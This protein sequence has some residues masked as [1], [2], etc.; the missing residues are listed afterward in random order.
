MQET[1]TISKDEKDTSNRMIRLICS[2][3]QEVQIPYSILCESNLLRALVDD[4]AFIESK[5]NSILLPV[6]HSSLKR[7]IEYLYY[8]QNYTINRMEIDDFKIEDNETLDLL[9]VSAFL[10]L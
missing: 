3:Q 6:T 1:Q 7:I 2:T 8:K 5:N 10:R 4:K 9:E